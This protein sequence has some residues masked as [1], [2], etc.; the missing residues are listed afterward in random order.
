MTGMSSYDDPDINVIWS[1]PEDDGGATID[2]YKIKSYKD[3]VFDREELFDGETFTW[4]Y[5]SPTSGSYT[6][7]FS[8]RNAIGYSTESAP[9]DPVVVP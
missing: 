7:T 3:T 2:G 6:F 4:L 9:I 1:P 8:A 5:A